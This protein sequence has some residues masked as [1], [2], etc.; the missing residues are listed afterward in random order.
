MPYL[1]HAIKTMPHPL[2]QNPLEVKKVKDWIETESDFTP[3]YECKDIIVGT[4]FQAVVWI[5]F[6]PIHTKYKYC[7]SCYAKLPG[8]K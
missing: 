2:D 1:T 7:A 3:C 8:E 4:M 5:G 6:E